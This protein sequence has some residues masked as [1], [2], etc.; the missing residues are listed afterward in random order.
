MA[1]IK[2]DTKLLKKF[3]NFLFLLNGS[4]EILYTYNHVEL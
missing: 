2:N 1:S 4:K 3:Q